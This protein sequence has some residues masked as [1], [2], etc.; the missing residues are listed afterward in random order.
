MRRAQI[1]GLPQLLAPALQGLTRQ[2]LDQIEAPAAEAPA[3][4]GRLQPARRLTHVRQAMATAQLRQ[5]GIVE[6]LH[7]QAHPGDAGGQIALQMVLI[8]AGGIQLQGEFGAGGDAV[9]A[10]QGAQQLLQLRRSQQRRGAPTHIH[11]GEGR[12]R[13]GGGDL[14]QQLIQVVG[15]GGAAGLAGGGASPIPQGHHREIAVKATPVAERDVQVGA[16]RGPAG[17]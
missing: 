1:D 14:L 9:A 12:P 3:P 4:L 15:D 16:A 2:R 17:P 11:R 13:R 5:H 7:P 6:A 8:K 10:A